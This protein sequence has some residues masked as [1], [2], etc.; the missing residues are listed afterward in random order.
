MTAERDPRQRVRY[1][2][3]KEGTRDV[4]FALEAT[5]RRFQKG[6]RHKVT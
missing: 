4:H 3:T 5:P 6:A 2:L 1:S